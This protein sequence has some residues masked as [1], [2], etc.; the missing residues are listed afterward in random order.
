MSSSP[1]LHPRAYLVS[2][3]FVDDPVDERWRWECP[4]GECGEY[5]ATMD[6]AAETLQATQETKH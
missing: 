3:G 1:C 2:D 4:C 6:E 5:V